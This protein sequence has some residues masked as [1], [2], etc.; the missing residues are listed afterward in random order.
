MLRNL[1]DHLRFQAE[2]LGPLPALRHKRDGLYYDLSWQE[3]DAD[4]LACAAALVEA[5]V[6]AGD[7]VGVL[8]ENRLEWLIAD[9]GL[10]AAGAVNVPPHAPLTAKQ[11][12]FQLHD[13]GVSWL[14]VSTAEQLAK[15]R[16]V[17]A[18]D[19]TLV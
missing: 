2:R 9:M 7:R 5:G 1:A 14:F 6:Q 4:A 10:L 18:A 13:A 16:A 19:R 15:I 8:S 3:Y 17:R 12:H 11:V